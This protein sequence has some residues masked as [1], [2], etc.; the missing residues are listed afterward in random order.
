MDKLLADNSEEIYSYVLNNSL[1]Q[2]DILN[3]LRLET[4]TDPAAIM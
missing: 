2:S 4:Q 1:R 3:K